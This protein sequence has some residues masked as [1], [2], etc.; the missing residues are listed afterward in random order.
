[1]ISLIE[2][3]KIKKHI[4]SFRNVFNL[5]TQGPDLLFY[6]N[7]WPWTKSKGIPE[8]GNRL[9]DAKTGQFISEALKYSS[10]SEEEKKNLL[11]AYLYGYLCH[12]ALDCHTHPYIFYKTGFVRKDEKYSDKYT[13]Y[14]R[15]FETALDVFMLERELGLKPSEF[16]ASEKIRISGQASAAIGEMH[17]F[18]LEKLYSENISTAAVCQAITDIAAVSAALRDRT[19]IKKLLLE[20]VE[21]LMGKCPMYSSM[22]L[23]LAIKD[24][25]DYLNLLHNTWSLPW[26]PESRHTDSF[27]DMFEA[28]AAE[29][30]KLC[31]AVSSYIYDGAEIE[32][33]M[34]LIGNRSFSTGMDCSLDNEFVT[35]DCIYE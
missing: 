30:A 3:D 21:K 33:V 15:M 20:K 27:P 22:I 25:R 10:C 19:G 32:E 5:G 11:T 8:V 24:R 35:Y 18:M 28:A 4:S 6:Y 29:A 14:H 34:S 16:N 26:D 7:A 2:D 23:P 17:S 12:Y 13:C 1:M 31:T 9:H